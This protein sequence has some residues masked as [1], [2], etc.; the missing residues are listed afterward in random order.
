[1][2]IIVTLKCGLDFIK[3]NETPTIRKLGWGFLFAF[4]SNYGAILYR[5]IVSET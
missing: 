1:M 3:V 5:L 4:Y 2:N